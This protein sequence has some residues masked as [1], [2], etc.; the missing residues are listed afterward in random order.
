MNT[1]L[2]LLATVLINTSAPSPA[3][4][5]D[6][7]ADQVK[8]EEAVVNWANSAFIKHLD[9]KFEHFKAHY[10]DD[11]FI[12][13]MRLETYNDKIETL[14]SKKEA[15]EYHGTD[16]QYE[17][18]LRK[19]SNALKRAE[20]TISHIDKV[21]H[22]ETHFW[23]NIQTKDGITVYY[24]LIVKLDNDYKVTEAKEN[25]SI[26][27]KSAETKIAYQKDTTVVKVTEK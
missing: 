22:Y 7:S 24:E 23:T 14:K 6:S 27:K 21:S 8:V 1:L 5:I 25:S 10:T 19:L 2:S 26:G 3:N 17:N 13:T 15:G 16:E 9:Y 12:Q 18:D 4:E 20:E 11:Y